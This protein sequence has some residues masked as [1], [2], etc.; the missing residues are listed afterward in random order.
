M[1]YKTDLEGRFIAN[2]IMRSIKHIFV[3][4]NTYKFKPH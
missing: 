1:S 2:F 3:D 4:I